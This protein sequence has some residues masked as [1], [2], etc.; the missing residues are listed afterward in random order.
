MREIEASP[1]GL[2]WP[3]FPASDK[4]GWARMQKILDFLEPRREM[5]GAAIPPGGA[6]LIGVRY[7]MITTYAKTSDD[8]V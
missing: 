3:P 4:E 5:V 8:E 6:E 7:P 2:T 1:R